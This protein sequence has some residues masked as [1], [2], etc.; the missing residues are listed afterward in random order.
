MELQGNQI[1]VCG[2]KNSGKS[3]FVKWLLSRN[4]S[5][6]VFDPMN[7]YRDQWGF[8]QYIPESRRGKEAEEELNLFLDQLIKPNQDQLKFCV[9]EECNRFHTKQGN[10]DGA[11][12]EIVD[13][14]SSHWNMGTVFISRKITQ[15]HS[16]IRGLSDYW[17]IFNLTDSNN[18]KMLNKKVAD[19]LGD[20]V[21]NLDPDGFRCVCV[22]PN[23]EDYFIMDKVPLQKNEKG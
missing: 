20:A 16:D 13:V 18:V 21:K 17:F 14:G 22:P 1:L 7:E 11:I 4:P 10:L 23:R 12:G 3:N 19:G 5:H 2:L 9:I 6:L 8:N 15:I